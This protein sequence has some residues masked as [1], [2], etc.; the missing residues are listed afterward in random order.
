MTKPS[1]TKPSKKY[2]FLPFLILGGLLLAACAPQT[3]VD[4]SVATAPPEVEPTTAVV[5]SA[6]SAESADSPDPT[7]PSEPTQQPAPTET[8]VVV[9]VEVQDGEIITPEAAEQETV[10]TNQ[11][12]PAK[13]EE[14][15]AEMRTLLPPDAIPS[16]DNPTF[17]TSEE[18]NEYYDPDELIIGVVFDGEARAYSIPHLSSHEIVNDEVSGVKIA[19]TW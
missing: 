11:I 18:A 3:T 8:E 14:L 6:E 19:V 1:M 2:A 13:Y 4:E 7:E 12:D 15:T 5:E 17:H 9:A 16:I 10:A